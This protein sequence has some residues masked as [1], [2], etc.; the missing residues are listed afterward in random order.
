MAALEE[1]RSIDK[2]RLPLRLKKKLASETLSSETLNNLAAT[3]A[4]HRNPPTPM[5][6]G[7]QTHI[8][9]VQK[10]PPPIWKHVE[11]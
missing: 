6:F 7:N 2:E 9:Q 10:N 8:G 3:R 5:K 11:G 4:A 1:L